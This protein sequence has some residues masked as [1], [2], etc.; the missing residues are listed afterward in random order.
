MTVRAQQ[1]ARGA[2]AARAPTSGDSH[3]ARAAIQFASCSAPSPGALSSSSE[4]GSRRAASASRRR[5]CAPL[6]PRQGIGAQEIHDRGLQHVRAICAATSSAE[7]RASM[8]AMRPGSAAAR[9]QIG[10]AHAL[11]EL[12]ALAFEAIRGCAPALRCRAR[13]NA[14]STGTSS[15]TVRSGRRAP[16]T[17]VSS[18]RMSRLAQ[19]AAALPDRRRW[20]R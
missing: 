11:E 3:S 18:W 2:H 10:G 14:C 15:S 7:R 1:R 16:C 4:C 13:C 12:G 9:A 6:Q 20:H 19:A 8:T 17:M 5:C